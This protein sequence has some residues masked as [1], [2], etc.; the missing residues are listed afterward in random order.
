MDAEKKLWMSYLLAM[1]D[2]AS[3]VFDYEMGN[4]EEQE[5]KIREKNTRKGVLYYSRFDMQGGNTGAARVFFESSAFDEVA[6]DVGYDT[7]FINKTF[8]KIQDAI[9]RENNLFKSF[10]MTNLQ[11]FSHVSSKGMRKVL[12]KINK[13]TRISSE[14]KQTAQVA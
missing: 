2:D 13:E 10:K 9:T 12:A 14:N 3:G 5:I 6:N 11:R 7:L 8:A 4:F 1:A